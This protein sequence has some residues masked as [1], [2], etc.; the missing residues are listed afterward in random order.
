MREASD[1]REPADAES[2]TWAEAA[3]RVLGPADRIQ[4]RL[5]EALLKGQFDLHYQPIVDAHSGR[6]HALEAL[7]RWQEPQLGALSPG[8]F[9]PLAERSRLI[10]QI[11]HYVLDRAT[12]QICRWRDAGLPA[13]PVSV[14][15]SARQLK[16]ED[17]VS[18]LDLLLC[19]SGIDPALLQLEI[20]EHALIDDFGRAAQHVREASALGVSFALD[21]FGTGHS[22][23]SHLRH[24]PIQRIK[25]DREFVAG[26]DSD[27][28]DQKIVR[29][30]TAMAHALDLQ[31]VA[32]GVE[33]EAELVTLRR[34]RCD[35]VQGFLTGRPMDLAAITALLAAQA[36][37]SITAAKG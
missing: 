7:L 18:R 37:A 31:V 29:A 36:P 32:E 27:P 6:L 19:N 28:R 14:N 25:I 10:L 30:I 35:Q 8:Q 1:R 15:L 21:D 3:P 4:R 24:L 12:A 26:I 23:F 22:S 17:F 5:R 2:A 13:L 34:V 16:S 33:T 11:D 20:T 9:I